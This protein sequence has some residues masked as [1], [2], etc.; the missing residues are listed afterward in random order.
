MIVSV[1]RIAAAALASI[2]VSGGA[3][4]AGPPPTGGT[5]SIEAKTA[6]GNPDSTMAVFVDA[7]SAALTARGFTVFNDSGHAASVVELILGH[8]DVGTGVGKVQG[9]RSP[10]IAGTG[11]ALPLGTGNSE[12]VRLQRTRLEM[13]IHRR[14]DTA[15]VWDGAAVT[16]REAGIA[17]GGNATVATDLIRALLDSYPAQ[18]TGVIGV[19]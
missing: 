14:G 6:D 9:Q 3:L 2:L 18:P 19:P 12:L 4:A 7:A 15:I 11:L 8:G 17:K 1:K 13:R 10:S 16:V 5:V